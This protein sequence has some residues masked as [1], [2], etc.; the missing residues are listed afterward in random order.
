M[1][2]KYKAEEIFQIFQ[3]QHRLSQYI[4]SEHFDLEIESGKELDQ[5]ESHPIGLVYWKKY[6]SLFEGRYWQAWANNSE[7][8]DF[9]PD[10]RLYIDKVCQHLSQTRNKE[11]P[12][13][14]SLLGQCC[15]SASIFRHLKH[16]LARK[17]VPTDDLRPS[18]P[19]APYLN[20][21][22]WPMIEVICSS[23]K[24]V[25]DVFDRINHRFE[26]KTSNW[27][28]KVIPQFRW[29]SDW[30]TGEVKTFRHV[31]IQIMRGRDL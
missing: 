20:S 3:E 22:F 19:I 21:H 16:E 8:R 26:R 2:R 23:G 7:G 1:K 17:G 10:F 6:W 13:P 25:F 11:I 18:S 24:R 14:I 15:I 9:Q 30:D 28:S 5:E 12:E 4:D 31:V 27:R 29:V